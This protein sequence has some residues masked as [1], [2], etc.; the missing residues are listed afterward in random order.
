MIFETSV[1][2]QGEGRE[3]TPPEQLLLT[4]QAACDDRW[5]IK[6]ER[7]TLLEVVGEGA[8]GSVRRG[9]LAPEG[10]EVAVKMLQ[11]ENTT[12]SSDVQNHLL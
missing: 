10:K 11:G 9:V 8:F 2:Y 12:D 4:L 1:I 6:S 3:G 7:L 5:E